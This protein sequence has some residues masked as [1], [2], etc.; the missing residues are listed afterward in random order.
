MFGP[1][2]HLPIH[3][4]TMLGANEDYED[5]AAR[6]FSDAD[7]LAQD[8]RWDDAGHLMGFAAEC[9]VKHAVRRTLQVDVPRCHFPDLTSRVRSIGGRN[10]LGKVRGALN[11]P[12]T[13]TAFHDW[14]V[15]MRY[16]ASGHVSGDQFKVWKRA[17]GRLLAAAGVR[18]H[19]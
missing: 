3:P 16:R 8:C 13:P 11:R 2:S 14:A 7:L 18:N 15:D 17:A 6:H 10:A 9:A 5:A 19:P 1:L 4:E 12:G